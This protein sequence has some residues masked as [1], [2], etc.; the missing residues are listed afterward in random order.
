[1]FLFDGNGL[2]IDSFLFS[3]FGINKDCLFLSLDLVKMGGRLSFIS[4]VGNIKSNF[5]LLWESGSD[6]LG[7]YPF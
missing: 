3:F 7:S 4:P 6:S 1:M 2:Y 5:A